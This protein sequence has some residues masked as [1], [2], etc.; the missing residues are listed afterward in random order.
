MK[1]LLSILT[2]ISMMAQIPSLIIGC[3]EKTQKSDVE[4]D[5]S[6][7]QNERTDESDDNSGSTSE[8]AQKPDKKQKDLEDIKIRIKD[9]LKQMIGTKGLVLDLRHNV[10]MDSEIEFS[11]IQEVIIKV[12]K[13]KISKL[14]QK[15]VRI[16]QKSASI[17]AP[18][19]NPEAI[20]LGQVEIEVFYNNIK[21]ENDAGTDFTIEYGTNFLISSK[22]ILEQ[23]NSDNQVEISQIKLPPLGEKGTKLGKLSLDIGSLF[24]LLRLIQPTMRLLPSIIPEN[25]NTE[26]R[27]WVQWNNFVTAL[28]AQIKGLA[29]DSLPDFDLDGSLVKTI[30]PIVQGETRISGSITIKYRALIDSLL[31]TLINFKNF[32]D[33]EKEDGIDNFLLVFIKYLFKEPDYGTNSAGIQDGYNLINQNVYIDHSE[34]RGRYIFASNLEVLMHNILEGWKNKNGVSSSLEQPIAVEFNVQVIPKDDSPLPPLSPFKFKY[35][36][37]AASEEND[38]QA[39]TGLNEWLSDE[40]SDKPL[41]KIINLFNEILNFGS[42]KNPRF[43]IKAAGV[44]DIDS[45]IALNQLFT[46]ENLITLLKNIN[47]KLPINKYMNLNWNRFKVNIYYRVKND[48][49]DEISEWKK[50]K[51]INDLQDAIDMKMVLSEN[52]ITLTSKE[53]ATVK[54][55]IIPTKSIDI[56]FNIQSTLLQSQAPSQPTGANTNANNNNDDDE[57]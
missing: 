16:V 52:S 39:F 28:V 17:I 46:E 43:V 45:E 35:L 44:T 24:N 53:D 5:S 11:V 20:T 8:I 27:N 22:Q 56:I 47:I 23:L 15:L 21:I 14:N 36:K 48:D 30:G 3:G 29:G 54:L 33:S 2:V 7:Q 6:T 10:I 13:S 12:L 4:T 57:N 34:R 55:T 40:P 38:N 18:T 41:E 50:A 49:D 42:D 32:V 37:E 25:F 26:D 9:T 1:R 31:P 51:T 19:M